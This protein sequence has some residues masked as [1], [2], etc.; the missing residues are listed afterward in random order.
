MLHRLSQIISFGEFILS[1]IPEWNF[2]GSSTYQAEGS[3]SDMY[4]I[5]V[6]MFRDP[7]TL[8]PNKL[9][10][11][12]VFKYNRLPAGTFVT[13]LSPKVIISSEWT[14]STHFFLHFLETNHRISCNKVME[15]VKEHSIW[16]GMEQEY[17]LLGVDGHPFNWPSNG[18]PAPQGKWI[19]YLVNFIY[20]K[21][22]L[23]MYCCLTVI[24]SIH[25][26]LK[27]F[28]NSV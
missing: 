11:C 10:L 26:V 12:E 25:F 1:D 6:C 8:D 27:V 7:F 21:K 28:R 22:L 9:V 4:L 13:F 2:D 19:F 16:F 23:K 24:Q 5:P 15:E 20:T 18:Y 3:N 17:T 14:R